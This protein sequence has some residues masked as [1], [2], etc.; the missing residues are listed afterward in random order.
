M[1]ASTLPACGACGWQGRPRRIRCPRC[2]G[3]TLVEA[4]LPDATVIAITQV[5]RHLVVVVEPPEVICLVF[6]DDG[7]TFITRCEDSF[8][9]TTGDRVSLTFEDGVVAHRPRKST[10]ARS[11]AKRKLGP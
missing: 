5:R 2:E 9:P 6:T 4:P 7:T 1:S 3:T 10:R 11:G 8:E